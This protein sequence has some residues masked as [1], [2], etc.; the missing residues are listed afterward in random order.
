M[1]LPISR[2]CSKGLILAQV[3]FAAWPSFAEPLPRI[4]ARGDHFETVDGRRFVP[5]GVNWVILSPGDS[6]TAQNIS[7]NPDYYGPHRAQ[8]QDS[9]RHIAA[10][11][12]NLVRIRLDAET[13]DA[14]SL[15]NMI[16]FIGFAAGLGL[17]VEPTGQWLPPAYYGLVSGESWPEPNK[18]DTSGLNQLLLSRS[19]TRAYGRFIADLLK[20]IGNH[21]LLSAVF[22][23]DLWNE[24]CFDADRL[25]FSRDSGTFTAEWGQSFDL[26]ETRD[27]QALADEGARR[28]IDGVIAEARRVAP[29]TLF[30]SSAFAPAEIYRA[31]Y[32]GV[33]LRDAKW[34]DPR[35]PFRLTAIERSNLDFL[36]IHL[37][38]HRPPF[39]IES[40]LASVEFEGLTH[41]KPIFLGETAAAKSELPTT[42]AAARG[43]SSVVRQACAHHFAGWAYWTWNTDEQRDLWNLAEQDGLLANRLSPRS[44]DWCAKP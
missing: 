16:D 39:S 27:R 8:I 34:G 41:Q 26:A 24:L 21:R 7:F 31:G 10:G 17:Y 4:V 14:A 11:G 43:A 44:F 1:W 42:D 3:I 5:Q 32:G 38:P 6:H 18:R 30:T 13:F 37:N 19:L 33:R 20:G 2:R 25:P 12:F 35:Q 22:A 29:Q 36:Q 40:D 28:W 15:D 9:L 23:V